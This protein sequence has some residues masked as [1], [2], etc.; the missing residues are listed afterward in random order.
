MS[1]DS[2]RVISLPDELRVLISETMGDPP[3]LALPYY[4]LDTASVDHV[5]VALPAR[6][7]VER[8]WLQLSDRGARVVEALLL[9]PDEI[10]GCDPVPPEHKKWM[11]TLDVGPYWIV[12]LAPHGPDDLIGR[13]VQRAAGAAIHHIAFCVPNISRALESCLSVPG[14]R[15]ITVL[16]EDATLSQ[17]FLRVEDDPRIIELIERAEGFEGTFTCQNIRALTAGEAQNYGRP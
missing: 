9:W 12:L 10:P 1:Q 7:D 17:V 2:S 8:L 11:A 13:F 3:R 15:Q 6:S 14:V 4:P 16:A 5:A